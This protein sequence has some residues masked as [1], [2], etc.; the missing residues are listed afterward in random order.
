MCSLEHP[1]ACLQLSYCRCFSAAPKTEHGGACRHLHQQRYVG[2]FGQLITGTP[3][4]LL[5][6]DTA[7]YNIG[8]AK[9]QFI[10]EVIFQYC[11]PRMNCPLAEERLLG[12]G[13]AATAWILDWR[14]IREGV[15]TIGIMAK[16]GEHIGGCTGIRGMSC[17]ERRAPLPVDPIS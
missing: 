5:Y 14:L 12:T 6:S 4:T 1:S 3:G 7:V 17:P 9:Y 10:S 11:R 16:P 2:G 15:Q 13:V 8:L